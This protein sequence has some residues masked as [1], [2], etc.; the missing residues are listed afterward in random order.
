MGDIDHFKQINDRFGHMVGTMSCDRRPR[1]YA[2][3]CRAAISPFVGAA[4]FLVLFPDTPLDDAMVLAETVRN[5]I[6]AR[7]TGECGPV[8]M[9]LG[10]GQWR[11]SETVAAFVERVDAAMCAA[12]SGGRNRVVAAPEALRD[13]R[14]PSRIWPGFRAARYPGEVRWALL[15]HRGD[16]LSL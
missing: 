4:R 5:L 9:S 14:V 13:R 12:K 6:A 10:V 7:P 16:G 11:P 2:A 15:E 3:V 1:R 8:T